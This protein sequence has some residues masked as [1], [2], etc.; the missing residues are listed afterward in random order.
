[1]N[2]I[3]FISIFIAVLALVIQP[4]QGNPLLF[5]GTIISLVIMFIV[6]LHVLRKQEQPIPLNPPL[7]QLSD[8][9]KYPNKKSKKSKTNKPLDKNV[10]RFLPYSVNRKQQLDQM[11]VCFP[12]QNKRLMWFI[13]GDNNQC[14]DEFLECVRL[15]HWEDITIKQPMPPPKLIFFECPD[16]HNIQTFNDVIILRVWE[17]VRTQ[18]KEKMPEDMTTFIQT[19][20]QNY[21][22]PI[23]LYT[24]ITMG[25]WKKWKKTMNVRFQSLRK[26]M[27]QRPKHI[28]IVCILIVYDDPQTGLYDK[29]CQSRIKNKIRNE[30]KLNYKHCEQPELTDI[31]KEDLITWRVKGFVINV[32][33]HCD[34]SVL[35]DIF[36]DAKERL[37]M[38]N[39]AKKIK[40]IF[41]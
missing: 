2:Y 15:F 3:T 13:H 11:L 10:K 7:N 16:I 37:P 33:D 29:F 5:C 4:L 39:L 32:C 6:G 41:L 23:I 12:C 34:R 27:I 36:S 24:K 22:G 18:N 35:D 21:D 17:K 28:L 1:M 26:L 25:D 30:L 9:P 14:H 20:D 38:A 8:Q 40:Q 31:G 19:I